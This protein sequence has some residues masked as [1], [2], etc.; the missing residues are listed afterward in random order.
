[1]NL[2]DR[3]IFFLY[4]VHV[5]CGQWE[6]SRCS[7]TGLICLEIYHWP[8]IRATDLHSPPILETVLVYATLLYYF[9]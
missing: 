8:A 4:L 5:V 6:H 9:I 1:M 3:I 2:S 7:R